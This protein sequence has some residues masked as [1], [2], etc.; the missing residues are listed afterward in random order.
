MFKGKKPWLSKTLWINLLAILALFIQWI[1]GIDILSDGVQMTLLAAVN[2]WL[3]HRTSEPLDWGKTEKPTCEQDIRDMD[4][5]LADRDP[6]SVT[7]L[8]D[9]LPGN[10][11]DDPWQ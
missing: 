3:R 10:S 6:A 5:A 2:L 9:K 4:K 8:F 7:A 1:V 11:P